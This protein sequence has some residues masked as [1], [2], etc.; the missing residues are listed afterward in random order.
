MLVFPTADEHFKAVMFFYSDFTT[1]VFQSTKNYIGMFLRNNELYGVYKL[2]GDKYEIKT[3]AITRS[4]LEPATF[5]R[6]DLRR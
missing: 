6:V 2:N 3:G 5:D 4:G 1:C